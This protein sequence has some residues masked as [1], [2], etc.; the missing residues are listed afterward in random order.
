[1]VQFGQRDFY[2]KA[3]R[4]LYLFINKL[5]QVIWYYF[6]PFFILIG[7]YL[8]NQIYYPIALGK[9]LTLN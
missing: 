6:S 7:T 9:N 8:I 2:S 4:I 5:Y 3:L 1:M